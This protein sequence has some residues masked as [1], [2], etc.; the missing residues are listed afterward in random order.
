[1]RSRTRL[2]FFFLASVVALSSAGALVASQAGKSTASPG[3]PE[4]KALLAQAETKLR[5]APDYDAGIALLKQAIQADTHFVDAYA[6]LYSATQSAAMAKANQTQ[7]KTGDAIDAAMNDLKKQYATWAAADPN[8]AILAWAQGTLEEK[9]WAKAKAFYD[10]AIA[11]DPYFARTYLQ[12]SLIADFSGDNQKQVDYLKKAAD[13]DPADPQYFFYWA[14]A[15]KSIDPARSIVLLQQTA[16]KYPGT[17]RGA[18]GLY[19]AAFET[20]DLPKK[21]AIYERLH[22]DFPPAKS[23]W[24]GS[25]MPALFEAYERTDPK[26]ALAFA[27]GLAAEMT[28]ESDK[29]TW[30]DFTAY[31]RAVVDAQ[32]SIDAGK[33]ADAIALIGKAPR[34]RYVDTS[35]LDL[36]KASAQDVSGATAAAYDGLLIVASKSPTDAVNAAIATYGKKLGKGAAAID[37]DLWA[38]LEANAK[39]AAD[40]ALPDYPGGKTVRLADY[41]GKVVLVNFWYPSC[42]PCRGEFPT[43]Q[44]VLTKYQDR[45]FVILALNVY[46]DEDEFVMPYMTNNHFTF[47]PLKTDT[48][49]AE[50]NYAARGYPT[51]A[52]VDASGRVIFKPGVVRGEQEQR[53]L[54]LQVEMLLAHR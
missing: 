54:E 34:P 29:K 53:T 20:T 31:A 12:L 37:A 44:R 23:G 38:K 47:R 43:L 49:W 30:G 17:E 42:G 7:A 40:F 9:D 22:R 33:G 52:L 10:R 18:Q 36:L 19:W 1:M 2:T 14:S 50:K 51:N 13:V 8:N 11:L 16:D 6:R 21:I 45:G 25:G 26:K 5:G 48:D 4:A 24:S 27:Q 39:P 41:R 32:A 46:P 35:A 28:D 15:M 3:T